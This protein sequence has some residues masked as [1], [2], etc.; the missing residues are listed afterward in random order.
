MFAEDTI[1]DVVGCLEFDPSLATPK[2][3]REYLKSVAKFHQVLFDFI[4]FFCLLSTNYI[5]LLLPGGKD[6]E[7][8]TFVKNSPNVPNSIYSSKLKISRINETTQ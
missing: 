7:S 5:H 8:S 1:F 2:K 4:H 3:H 6:Y